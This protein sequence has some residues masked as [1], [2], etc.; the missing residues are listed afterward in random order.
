MNRD[1]AADLWYRSARGVG[2]LP[3]GSRPV[4]ALGQSAVC[5]S[6]G[7]VCLAADGHS[8]GRQS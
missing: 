5:C 1:A 6:C 3:S 2:P 4:T 7:A 8:C